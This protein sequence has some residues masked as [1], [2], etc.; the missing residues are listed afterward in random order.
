MIAKVHAPS[1]CPLPALVKAHPVYSAGRGI[2]GEGLCLK[3]P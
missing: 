1:P 3:F 2:K